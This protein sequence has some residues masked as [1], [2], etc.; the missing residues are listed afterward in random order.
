MG[1]HDGGQPFLLHDLVGEL[2]D[3]LRGFGVQRRRML[4]QDQEVDG[5][6]GGHQKG[7]GLPLAAGKASHL[8]LQLILQ[9]QVQ[10]A[11]HFPVMIDAGFVC[12][13]SQAKKFSFVVSHCQ[14]F[15]DR[16]VGA[17]TH[18]RILVNPSD[19]PKPPVLLFPGD[20]LSV[21]HNG[22]GVQVNASADQVQQRSLSGTVASH[23]GH[24]LS[25]LHRQ[26]KILK[27]AHFIDCARI[28]IFRDMLQF[29]HGFLLSRLPEAEF[30]SS[31]FS[32]C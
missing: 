21:H 28:V 15:Q 27:Q 22:S 1:Y 9:A 11:K 17:G 2:H 24:K 8:Y 4:I 31:A 19:S 32:P 3:P 20:I 10:L 12:A 7:H 23:H 25:V 30:F 26:I 18:G 14:I 29:K 6:H 16:H 13:P 5:R